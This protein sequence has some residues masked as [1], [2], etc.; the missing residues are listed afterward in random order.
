MDFDLSNGG[1]GLSV[2]CAT[3]RANGS[4]APGVLLFTTNISHGAYVIQLCDFRLT[5]VLC[6]SHRRYHYN[7]LE[8]TVLTGKICWEMFE[9]IVCQS[10]DYSQIKRTATREFVSYHNTLTSISPYRPGNRF[11]LTFD[12][13][14]VVSSTFK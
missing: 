1:F 7:I 11:R 5:A 8:L 9:Q 14:N 10:T 3:S 2:K 4:K 13:S 6:E 12:T